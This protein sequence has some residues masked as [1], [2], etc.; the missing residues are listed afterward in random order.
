MTD[1][2]RKKRRELLQRQMQNRSITKTEKEHKTMDLFLFRLYV[3]GV[4]CGCL[5]VLS[6]FH[7]DTSEYVVKNVK[8]NI[9]KE[10]P[11][12]TILQKG[13]EIKVFLQNNTKDLPV[14]LK[15]EEKETETE[16]TKDLQGE[17]P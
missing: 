5:F 12:E 3:T 6:L 1:K 2:E 8:E 10:I 4:I 7:T 16:E 14:F 13:E 9:A 17:A 15:K 11:M